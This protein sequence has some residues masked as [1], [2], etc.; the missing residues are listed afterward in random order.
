VNREEYLEWMEQALQRCGNKSVVLHLRGIGGIGKSS[1]LDYWSKTIEPTIKLDCNQH[2]EFF[3][4][5]NVLARG[6]ALLGVSLRHFNLLWQIRQRFVEGVEPAQGRDWGWT[7]DIMSLI[8]FI[9]SL[10]AIGNAVKSVGSEVA[11]KLK[12]RFRDVAKWLQNKLGENPVEKLLEI[13]WKYPRQA[14]FLYLD[15]L[16]EDINNRKNSDLPILFLLDHYEY[17]DSENPRWRYSGKQITESQLWCVFLTSISCCVGVMASRRSMSEQPGI[18]IEE[19]EIIELCQ[20]SCIELLDLRRVTDS[21]IQDNI[22]N[23]SG[24]NPFL[25]GTLCDMAVSGS[26]SLTDIEDLRA[27]TLEEVRLKIWKRLFRDTQDLLGL[28]DRAG[29]LPFFDRTVMN[30]VS[31]EMKT[32]QWQRLINLSFVRNRGDGTYVL[33]GLARELVIA[34]LNE[35]I[36]LLTGNL[37]EI[38]E[39]AY[40]KT[41]DFRHLGM[42]LS[43]QALE[44]EKDAIKRTRKLVDDLQKKW[45]FADILKL[46]SSVKFESNEGR[47]ILLLLRGRA[48]H[49]LKRV[50][51]G[52]QALKEALAIFESLKEESPDHYQKLVAATLTD[53]GNLQK[54]SDSLLEGEKTL[55]DALELW[56]QLDQETSDTHQEE[57]AKTLS[58]LAEISLNSFRLKDGEDSIREALR[59]YNELVTKPSITYTL[60]TAK[61]FYI[62][63]ILLLR[64]NRINES[65]K[66][67]R[68][69]LKLFEKLV[70]SESDLFLNNVAM[71]LSSLGIL[72]VRNFEFAEAEPAY[73]KAVEI[74][75]ELAQ[76][77]PDLYL[78][79]YALSLGRLGFYL[80]F[81]VKRLEEAEDAYLEAL[82]IIEKLVESEPDVYLI[83][84]ANYQSKLAMLYAETGRPQEAQDAFSRSIEIQRSLSK[85]APDAH[86][87]ELARIIAFHGDLLREL[88]SYKD[89]EKLIREALDIV[90]KITKTMQ[91]AYWPSIAKVAISNKLVKLLRDRAKYAEA[92]EVCET[93]LQECKAL[94]EVLPNY[95]SLLA[96]ITLNNQAIVQVMHSNS[97]G[98]ELKFQ[99]A[100]DLIDALSEKVPEFALRFHAPILN[101]LAIFHRTNDSLKTA[102]KNLSKS[103][104]SKRLL[105]EKSPIYTLPSLAIS[106]NNFAIMMY[107]S[108]QV[109]KGEE[110]FLKALEIHEKL[111]LKSPDMYTSGAKL[112]LN[113]IAFM[114]EKM[115]KTSEVTKDAV[116]RLSKMGVVSDS[117]V[118]DWL[119]GYEMIDY[120]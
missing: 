110:S 118:K 4:R 18:D 89:A 2:I 12:I 1:L 109:T 82:E 27:N 15:A 35:R 114:Q 52:E 95:Y 42:A 94:T 57:I 97:K 50:A 64:S 13:L 76:K 78:S 51:D 65:E 75:R 111:V 103:L 36:N 44:S 73:R 115:G 48:L 106:L 54:D 38:L 26:L 7:M 34:E 43:V 112:T 49:G 62:L 68:K 24:G 60:E 101:N 40:A 11:L 31:P 37:S 108:N 67:T 30:L 99:E 39:N 45:R 70:E 116:S 28:V 16:L 9:G 87:I 91:D 47:G 93:A 105:A 19:S 104:T 85:K 80:S 59:I 90:E 86:S 22:V 58:G 100:L 66:A 96:A 74:R 14:E 120:A 6:A 98:V 72:Y 88:G 21:E 20:D 10:A 71:C 3:G 63:G 113:N 46:L 107:D 17:V 5:L 61:C 102:E 25:I 92:E 56:K 55:Q 84:Q 53:L 79:E 77:N 117:K 32:D 119:D 33:H 8:P 83:D 81:Y 29:L 23:I 69:A 41:S